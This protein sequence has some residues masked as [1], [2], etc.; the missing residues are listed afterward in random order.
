MQPMPPVR[1]PILVIHGAPVRI[2]IHTSR[3]NRR[4]SHARSGETECG[5][6][7]IGRWSRES[8]YPFGVKDRKRETNKWIYLTSNFSIAER[9]HLPCPFNWPSISSIPPQPTMLVDGPTYGKSSSVR[10]KS[11]SILSIATLATPGT[12]EQDVCDGQE[13][14][15]FD[16]CW[17]VS[18]PGL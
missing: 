15:Y 7:C 10:W 16:L 11:I 5:L 18:Q 3:A 1:P 14:G 2:Y 13:Q 8:T 6:L 12:H 9:E 17:F 4:P